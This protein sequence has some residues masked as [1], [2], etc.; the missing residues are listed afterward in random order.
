MALLTLKNLRL[1]Y[2]AEP[3]LDD[4]ELSVEPGERL[5]L[6]GRNG[7]GKSS[8]MQL[9]A[10]E[11]RPD[12]GEFNTADGLQVARLQ[13]D[14]PGAEDGTTYEVVAAGLP[15]AGELLSRYE[16]LTRALAD[17]DDSVFAEM[18]R[19][20]RELDSRGGWAL[21]Q[22]VDTVLSRMALDPS[23]PFADLSGG[24]KRRVLLARALVSD[25][26]LL[27]LDE[28]TNHLDIDAIHWLEEFL[29]DYPATLMFITHDRALIRSLATRIIELDR[30]KLTSWPGSYDRYLEKK[31]EALNAEEKQRAEFDKKLGRE[32]QW[33]RQGIKARR[34][35]NQGRVQELQQM[36]KEFAQRRER[37]GKAN[38]EIQD[39]ARSGKKVVEAEGLTYKTDEQTL[40]EDFDITIMRGDRIGVLGP[41]GCGKSTLLRVLLGEEEPQSGHVE[42]GTKLEVAYFDQLRNT[43]KLDES[44]VDNV[45]EGSDTVE[46]N[47]RPKHVMGY[48][49]DFLFEPGRARQP[50]SSLSG[51]ERN[52]LLLAKLFTKPF[53]LLVMDEPTNDLDVETLELLEEQLM[54]YKGT[55]LLVSHDR[56]FI[57]NVVTST[58][59]FEEDGPRQYVGG[60][61]D[62]IRQ[63]RENK[64][65]AQK[66]KAASAKRQPRKETSEAGLT[67]AEQLELK[68]L[69]EK[70]EELE[71]RIGALHS[72]MAEPDFFQADADTITGKQKELQALE[73]ELEDSF[74]RWEDLDSRLR[75]TEAQ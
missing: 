3:L 4:V 42:L 47:G 9:L 29:R 73:N 37:Q 68:D 38:L 55:L 2:G 74:A 46:I 66:K 54:E 59:A 63:R 13:Q 45:G 16:H 5:C 20:Q 67:Y 50:V 32:E 10:G 40:F 75:A 8:L 25:P 7:S 19:V 24:M 51:G 57:D 44:V 72:E 41:N 22:K 28:P 23:T 17:G 36:R 27:L 31:E 39:T 58:I 43:L 26:D 35:R 12:D 52:R 18:D 34:T 62:W 61:E 71:N 70:V 1:A 21:S 14:V 48:L 53:N 49:R 56:A 6:V 60:Y 64:P 30:G 65:A 33:I 15:E 11:L 69:P